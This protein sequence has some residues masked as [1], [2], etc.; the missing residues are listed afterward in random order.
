MPDLT[1]VNAAA[2]EFVM[3]RF[4]VGDDQPTL[5][6]ARR[7]RREPG[8]E[9]GRWRGAGRRELDDPKAASVATSSSSR[10]PRRW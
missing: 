2:G 7:G 6:R 1:G 5:G 4:D 8:A 9:R 10:Q 3:G